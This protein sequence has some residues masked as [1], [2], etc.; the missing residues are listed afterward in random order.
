MEAESNGA[1]LKKLRLEKGFS[2]EEVQKQ[3]KVHLDILKAIEEDNF[4]NL[5]P[6][7]IKGFLKIYCKFLGVD[8]KLYLPDYKEPQAEPGAQ[9]KHEEPPEFIKNT[10]EKRDISRPSGRPKTKLKTVVIILSGIFLLVGLFN[11]GRK[12]AR[13]PKAENKP[14]ISEGRKQ[15]PVKAKAKPGVKADVRPDIIPIEKKVRTEN[16]PQ[17]KNISEIRM[18]ISAKEDC[19]IQLKVDKRLVFQN[20]L[21][22]GR[23][24]SWK[25][26]DRIELSLGNAGGIDLE[27]NSKVIS[28]LGRR[29]Q[30]LKN[31]VIT[32]NGLS[33]PQ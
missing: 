28:P 24:E 9:P 11:L 15:E 33:I 18:V 30:V 27:V 26:K 32:K 17:D 2:L 25:A 4:I 23:F 1:K 20:I 16:I 29:G 5:S 19:W 14:K 21:K 31:I 12:M 7:Y 3:T 13:A 8:Y 6:V 22:K 10:P